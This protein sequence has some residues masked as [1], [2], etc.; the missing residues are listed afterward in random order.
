VDALTPP[1]QLAPAPFSP[2]RTAARASS[3]PSTPLPVVVVIALAALSWLLVGDWLAPLATVLLCIVWRF[4]RAEEGPPVLALALTFQ[5]A[6]VTSGVFYYGITGRAL[7]TV[8][9]S[10][11]RTMV[12][13]GMGC[14]FSL[15][16]GLKLALLRRG[17]PPGRILPAQAF[18]V[19]GL[20]VTYGLL[21][22]AMGLIHTAAWQLS[23]LTQGI[24]ALG[25][26]RLVALYLI[27]RRLT[28][29]RIR[30]QP[31]L[32]LLSIEMLLGFTSFFASF[33]E[34]LML[35]ALVFLERFN[36][37]RIRHWLLIA[38]SAALI[39]FFG[40]LWLSIRSTYRSAFE[41]DAFAESRTARLEKVA[42]LS[43]GWLDSSLGQVMKDLDYFVDRLWA[44]YY[45]GLAVS[46][47][48]SVLPHEN[49]RILWGAVRH[50]LMP[51]LF[52][53][54]KAV[55]PSDSEMVRKYSGIWVAGAEENTSIAFGYAAESYI[56]FGLP[57][58]FLPILIYAFLM[59]RAYV[60][61]LRR[62][63][64]RELAIGLVTVI[65]WLSLYLFER[66]WIKTL[67]FSLTLMIF[68]GSSMFVLDRYMM[69]R[70]SRRR[71]LLGLAEPATSPAASFSGQTS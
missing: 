54:N 47:V 63:W 8:V 2:P 71:R 42:S 29:P 1:L 67:G 9:L 41:M 37:R 70:R 31:I 53:P 52:F 64:H 32:I 12:L 11:Y 20:Y 59:G 13:I 40:L 36:P 51:R 66:S 60:F 21:L 68:V 49:G 48:P 17:R 30:W 39:F 43:R 58:M 62:I 57:W 50:V 10:D 56:D 7:D 38:G 19:Q 26:L 15:F 55:L 65:F 4:L 34:P 27:L 22:G 16:L 61:F 24:L 28:A 5:W 14:V 23:A 3:R 45:P 6:Q 25:F 35:L 44:V 69:S 18:T 46:R 33:R